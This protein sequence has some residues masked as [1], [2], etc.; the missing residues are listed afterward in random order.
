M[1]AHTTF[2]DAEIRNLLTGPTGPVVRTVET[3][4]RRTGNLARVF[5]PVDKG[6]LRGSIREIIV[7][8]GQLVVGRVFTPLEYGRYQH[9]GTGVYAGR[10]PI[11]APPGKVLV[12][13]PKGGGPTIYTKRVK[14]TPPTKFLLRALRI[15]S[16]WPVRDH[17]G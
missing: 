10:G 15:A 16:P 9:D 5:V 11:E 7:I 12:F 17:S 3:V 2:R 8:R 14:G 6:T 1:P 13:V 4:A